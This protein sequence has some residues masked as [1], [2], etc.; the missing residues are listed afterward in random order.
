MIF[1]VDVTTKR[2]LKYLSGY[3]IYL[4]FDIFTYMSYLV[5]K[6]NNCSTNNMTLSPFLLYYF[7]FKTFCKNFEIRRI[8]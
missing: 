7:N 5:K 3:N 6:M 2:G 1:P 8:I 4:G